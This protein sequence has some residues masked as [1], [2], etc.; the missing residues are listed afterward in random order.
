MNYLSL[1]TTCVSIAFTASVFSRFLNRRSLYLLAWTFGL[2]L[3]GVGTLSEVI[4]TITY[5]GWVLKAWYLAGAML[6]AAWLGQG[7]VF[8]LVRKRGVAQ[9]I[10]LILGTV[11]LAALGLVIAAPLTSAEGGY[12]VQGPVSAQYQAILVRSGGI[13]ALT[14]ILN[15]FGTVAL[16]GGALYSGYLFWRKRV[17]LNRVVGNLL[18]ATGALAPAMAGSLIKAGITDILY[19]SELIGVVLMYAGFLQASLK[20]KAAITS[21]PVTKEPY[22]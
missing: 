13:V 16:V 17:L 5:N 19:A 22:S 21:Q 11:S 1:L 2:F 15:L 7:T 3:F 12:L 14:I 4:L 6:T 9:A 10:A 8:L 18:I 20:P